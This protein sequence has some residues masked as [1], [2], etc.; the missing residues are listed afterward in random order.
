ME[1]QIEI[2]KD[3][4]GYEGLY[5]VSNFGNVKSLPRKIYNNGCSSDQKI[6]GRFL[7]IQ[8]DNRGYC[9]IR[10]S[11]FGKVKSMRVHQLMAI[12]F[13]NHIPKKGLVIDHIDND[14]SNNCLENIQIITHRIN[15]CKDRINGTS[16]YTGVSKL[17]N[18][19]FVSS[20]QIKNINYRLG[21]FNNEIDAYNAYLKKLKSI[22]D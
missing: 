1:N 20:I 15:C 3:I 7:K 5:Q 9:I 19:K 4:A 13:F 10:L 21:L 22:N 16:K 14:R 2:W 11:C 18:G 6:K 17:S 8:K 12:S